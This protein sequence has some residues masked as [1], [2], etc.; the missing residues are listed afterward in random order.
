MFHEYRELITELKQS[1]IHFTKVFDRH[2]E[3]D[4]QIAEMVKSH[5]DQ[6]EVEAKKKEKLKEVILKFLDLDTLANNPW[7]K[8]YVK[9]TFKSEYDYLQLLLKRYYYLYSGNRLYFIN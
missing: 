4:E 2:N 6:F 7:L 5:A 3:L 8:F 9:K 1:D